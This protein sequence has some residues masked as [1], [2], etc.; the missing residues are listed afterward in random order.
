VLFLF[1][2]GKVLKVFKNDEKNVLGFDQSV[3]VMLEM[4]DDNLLTVAV[5]HGLEN[6]VKEADIVLLDYTPEYPTLPVPRQIVVKIL[7]GET[8]KAIWKEYVEK[9]RKNKADTD[10]SSPMPVHN[11]R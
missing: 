3:L 5:Q 6:R 2:P 7:R 9:N 8:G 4:W 1:H 10:V 11:V